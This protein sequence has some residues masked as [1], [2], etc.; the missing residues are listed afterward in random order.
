MNTERLLTLNGAVAWL[1]ER[2][3]RTSRTS[4]ARAFEAESI[5]RKLG[6]RWLIT[7]S[8]LRTWCRFEPIVV[9]EDTPP[10]IPNVTDFLS[11]KER[12]A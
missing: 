9:D 2:H 5:G 4:L 12:S 3:F 8:E 11:R 6:S 7:E 1:A 10:A